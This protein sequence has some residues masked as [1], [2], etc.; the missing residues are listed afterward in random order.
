MSTDN[1]EQG[2]KALRIMNPKE[3]EPEELWT[4]RIFVLIRMSKERKSNK[5]DIK[6]ERSDWVM[7]TEYNQ[8]GE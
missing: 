4:R 8:Q 6:Q 2:E 1:N 3:N 5:E 7:N